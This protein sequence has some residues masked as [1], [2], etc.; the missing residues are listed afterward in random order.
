MDFVGGKDKHTPIF[1]THKSRQHQALISL[2]VIILLQKNYGYFPTVFPPHLLSCLLEYCKVIPR[3]HA[4]EQRWKHYYAEPRRHGVI[5]LG[6][7]L[8]LAAAVDVWSGC[9]HGLGHSSLSLACVVYR[10]S[11]RAPSSSVPSEPSTCQEIA[12]SVLQAQ[13]HPPT[14]PVSIFP[15]SLSSGVFRLCP[16]PWSGRAGCVGVRLAR[17]EQADRGHGCWNPG[18]TR[19]AEPGC[20]PCL[21]GLSL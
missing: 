10:G 13:P 6:M 8:S 17:T 18:P 7:Q 1:L 21:F 14:H 4:Q 11:I 3:H 15:P 19:E 20:K 5:C 12:L 2:V 16:W 9:S